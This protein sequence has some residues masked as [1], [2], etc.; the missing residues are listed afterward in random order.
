VEEKPGRR[1]QTLS[2]LMRNLKVKASMEAGHPSSRQR[3]ADQNAFSLARLQVSAQRRVAALDKTQP[4]A[5]IP[6]NPANHRTNSV[7]TGRIVC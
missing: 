5:Q 1:K 6:S 3:R 2:R 4:E 7:V